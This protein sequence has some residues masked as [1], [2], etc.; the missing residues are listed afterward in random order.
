MSALVNI[1][2]LMN[3]R[4]KFIRW[5]RNDAH[6]WGHIYVYLCVCFYTYIEKERGAW[7]SATK[8][9]FRFRPWW[10]IT[11]SF[12]SGVAL[13]TI[14]FFNIYSLPLR[15]PNKDCSTWKTSFLL[16]KHFIRVASSAGDNLRGGPVE[17]SRLKCI[18]ALARRRTFFPL[19]FFLSRAFHLVYRNVA[20]ARMI[21][22]PINT[23]KG[24]RAFHLP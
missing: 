21:N 9:N 6:G 11:A 7:Y 17:W 19:F 2:S 24:K 16:P 4:I 10:I 18:P 20:A 22:N 1:C 14:L 15:R 3:K 5:D 8:H 12:I 13:I 23:A